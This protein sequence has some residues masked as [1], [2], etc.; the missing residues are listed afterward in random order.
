M[1]ITIFKAGVKNLFF[2][3][4]M[5]LIKRLIICS[6]ALKSAITPSLRGLTVLIFSWVL[7]CIRLASFP[8]A[9][10]FSVF[11]SIATI[12]GLSTTTLSLCIISVFAVPRSIAIDSVQKSKKAIIKSYITS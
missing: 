12:D 10:I 6:D 9:I 8:T 2:K 5:L 7:P 3:D 1:Q 11:L 4:G